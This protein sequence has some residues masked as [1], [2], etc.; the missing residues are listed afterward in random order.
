MTTPWPVRIGLYKTEVIRT[1]GRGLEAVEFETLVEVQQPPNPRRDPAEA[2]AEY[3]R[4]ALDSHKQSPEVQTEDDVHSCS[5]AQVDSQPRT[6]TSGS[7][8]I[9]AVF[10]GGRQKACSDARAWTIRGAHNMSLEH[11]PSYLIEAQ[12]ATGALSPGSGVPGTALPPRQ[13]ARSGS[14]SGSG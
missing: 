7:G 14:S 1:R 6:R 3:Y 2:E 13:I 11:S 12:R 8:L 4:T 10:P 5:F 9:Q